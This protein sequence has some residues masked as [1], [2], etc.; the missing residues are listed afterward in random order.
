MLCS[1]VE[2]RQLVILFIGATLV[3]MILIT[4]TL[5]CIASSFRLTTLKYTVALHVKEMSAG[6][7]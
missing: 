1:G 4:A 5:L 7:T 3:F 6:W 2:E